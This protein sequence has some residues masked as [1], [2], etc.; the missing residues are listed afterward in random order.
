MIFFIIVKISHLI[1][2]FATFDIISF[3]VFKD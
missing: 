3:I 2:V 1:Q